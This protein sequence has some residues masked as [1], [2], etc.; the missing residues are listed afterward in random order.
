MFA[1]HMQPIYKN[2]CIDIYNKLN[3][4]Q[5]FNGKIWNQTKHKWLNKFNYASI[6]IKFRY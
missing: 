1:V 2:T 6:C 4:F 3:Q 5:Y